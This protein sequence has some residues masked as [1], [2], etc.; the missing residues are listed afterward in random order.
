M[1]S[2]ALELIPY[3]VQRPPDETIEDEHWKDELVVRIGI[4]GHMDLTATS[5]PLVL[6]AIRDVLRAYAQQE[7]TGVSCIAAGSDSLFADAVLERGGK[8]EVILPASDYRQCRVK[9]EHAELFDGLVARATR[10]RVMPYG[11]SNR[12]AYCT[13]PPTMHSLTPLIFSW[14][15][16]MGGLPSTAGAPLPWWR[17]PE[18]ETST[19]RLS[20]RLAPNA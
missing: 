20:G 6:E 2:Y 16:G 7:L 14:P 15:S 11:E 9:P 13:K 19:S 17:Q 1:R 5:I 12:A 8:L 10:V 18:P 3:F 4:T